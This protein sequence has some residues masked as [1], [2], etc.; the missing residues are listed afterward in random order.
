MTEQ[1][2]RNIE[3]ARCRY[4]SDDA[5]RTNIASGTGFVNL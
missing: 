4:S 1:D 2:Q 5:E 3:T